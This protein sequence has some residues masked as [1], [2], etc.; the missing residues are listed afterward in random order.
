MRKAILGLLFMI[1]SASA[2]AQQSPTSDD[3]YIWL[4]DVSGQRSMDWVNS[5]N[6]KTQAVLESDPR[7]QQY[8]DEALAIAQAK[9]RI[10]YGSVPRRKDLQFLAGRGSCSR[11]LAA[12]HPAELSERQ[13]GLANRA[14]P[15]F[16]RQDRERELGVER[17][18][19]RAAHGAALSDQP[20]RRRRGCGHGPRVRPRHRQIR[21]ERFRSSKGQAGRDLG[22]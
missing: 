2:S 4:E 16:A 1:G 7:Y 15:R 17:R 11:R 22:R 9:D 8:Y 21:A 20:L 18:T 14:R 13:S 3:P 10:P 6:A 19:M 12:D 5:H